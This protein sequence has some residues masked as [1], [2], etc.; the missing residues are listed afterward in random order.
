MTGWLMRWLTQAGSK[1][2][3]WKQPGVEV[4][5]GIACAMERQQRNLALEFV[6]GGFAALLLPL[7][8]IAGLPRAAGVLLRRAR[9]AEGRNASAARARFDTESWSLELLKHLDWRRFEELC[10]A[11][12]EALGFT[13]EISHSRANGA[14]DI[15]LRA[16][17][18]GEAAIIVHCQPWNAYRVGAKP[19]RELRAAM[20]SAGAVEGVLVTSSRYTQE[21]VALAA[22]ENVQLIDGADLLAKLGALPP[23]KS[24][25]LLEFATQGDFLTPTCPRCSIKMT[26]RRS[27]H[28][29]RKFWG[30]TNYPRC[31]QTLYRTAD[32]PA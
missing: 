10:A 25:G 4:D 6:R 13:A 14:V 22:K 17:G 24:R 1:P 8:W 21:A 12:F 2:E 29:G 31:K 9:S 3:R 28:E 16:A 19:V 18:A 32:A 5:D 20:T 26:S 11:Y 15:G 30:C 23:E 27:T 7:S